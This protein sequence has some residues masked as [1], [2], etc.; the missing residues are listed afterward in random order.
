[1]P[2]GKHERNKFLKK[3]T[4]APKSELSMTL[5]RQTAGGAAGKRGVLSLP[6]TETGSLITR[7]AI[8]EE[9]LAIT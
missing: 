9:F 6:Q 5:T 4:R 7:A 2:S 8:Q 1:M 3:A